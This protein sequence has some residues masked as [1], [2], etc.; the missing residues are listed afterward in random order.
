MPPE[1]R[2]RPGPQR[3]PDPPP[4]SSEGKHHT[5]RPAWDSA[6]RQSPPTPTPG[7]QATCVHNA[8]LCQQKVRTD[9]R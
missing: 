9:L 7:G 6:V 4:N 5:T 1:A 2:H 8:R 3:V